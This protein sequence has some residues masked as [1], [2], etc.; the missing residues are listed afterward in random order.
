MGGRKEG[1]GM[2]ISRGRYVATFNRPGE[3]YHGKRLERKY[4][5]MKPSL[6]FVWINERQGFQV[7][8]IR[9]RGF[10]QHFNNFKDAKAWAIARLKEL[11]P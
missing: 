2:S 3:D 6:W 4:L 7:N 11:S 1:W 10:C 8:Q 5:D 9:Q